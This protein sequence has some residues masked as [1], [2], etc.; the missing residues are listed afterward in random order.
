MQINTHSHEV[1]GKSPQLL[2]ETKREKERKLPGGSQPV[3]D[4]VTI[5]IPHVDI[6]SSENLTA[7]YWG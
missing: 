2:E 3:T 1:L 7:T 4:R 6:T 5:K